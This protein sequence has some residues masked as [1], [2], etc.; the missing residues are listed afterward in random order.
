MNDL[1]PAKT[2]ELHVHPGGCLTAQDLLEL[3]RDI[4][5]DV[6]WTLFADAYEKAYGIC[7]NPITLYQKAL[8][9]PTTGFDPFKKH[10]I[11]TQED[12]GD[13]GRFQAKFNF[14]ICLLRH[15]A[16]HQDMIKTSFQMTVDQHKKEDITFI[17]YRCGGG[18]QT[19][20]QFIAMH[21]KY[22]T[23]LKNATND[24]FTGR[25]II[26]LRRWNP[27]QD[28][29]WVQELMDQNPDLIPTIIGIDFS[30][31]EEG[32]PPKDKKAF[33]KRVHQDNQKNPQRALDIVYHVGESYFDKSLESAIRWCHEAAEMG[34]KR[35]GHATALGLP[36]HIA[37]TRRPNA[38]VQELV[39]ERLD[40]IAYDLTHK[41]DLAHY[42]ITV[43]TNALHTEQQSLKNKAPNDLIERTY[44]PQRLEDIQKRQQ[45]VLNRLAQLG[46]VIE[47][48]PTS[49]LR[50]GGVPDP[51][52]HPIHT[53]L[54]SNVNL[55]IGA[56]DPG[57]FDSPLAN[58][59]DWVL[60]H[61]SWTEKDLAQRLGDPRRFQ[62]G[63]L[64]PTYTTR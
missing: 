45:Y 36:P 50:I 1:H 43:D 13:F 42:G 52:H 37:I 3:G 62:L 49:N 14:L 33:F 35:L 40:Q 24:H 29:E 44:H 2:C 21:H 51:A 12:G 54:K 41:A 53:F 61:T 38:H 34:V 39:S 19:H 26:S 64:R 9:D 25:Y 10:F 6:D 48:C 55:A 27:E 22:A 11:Y 23:I 8:A 18:D 47:T 46:T 17:E 63:T 31:F 20:D 5:Q 16:P 30:H 15:P 58:E 32:F 7:P 4:Y 28:Y 56:D 59:I 60:T 57:I